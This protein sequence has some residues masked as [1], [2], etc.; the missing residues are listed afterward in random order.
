MRWSDLKEEWRMADGPDGIEW[1]LLSRPSFDFVGRV[2]WRAWLHCHASLTGA[3]GRPYIWIG[4][5]L[6]VF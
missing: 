4:P 2:G 3:W 6:V 1:P 5:F